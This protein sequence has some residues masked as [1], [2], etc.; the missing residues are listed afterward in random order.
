MV[1]VLFMLAANYWTDGINQIGLD[2]ATQSQAS[3]KFNWISR[4]RRKRQLSLIE[5]RDWVARTKQK[6]PG[7][8]TG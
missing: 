6:T 8:D 5:P 2:L 3:T 7:K 4:Q 1:I